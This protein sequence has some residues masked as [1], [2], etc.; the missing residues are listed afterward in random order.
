MAKLTDQI[1]NFE[2]LKR[3]I[4]MVFVSEDGVLSLNDFGAILTEKLQ[5]PPRL[6]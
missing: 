3:I 2:S 4:S 6:T 1:V 5:T